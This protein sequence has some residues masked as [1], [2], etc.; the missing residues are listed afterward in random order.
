MDLILRNGLIIDGTGRQQF[1][2]DIGVS[3]GRI[4]AI[5][6]LGQVGSAQITDIDGYYVTPGII[7]AHTHGDLKLLK[8]PVNCVKL[9]QGVTC[10][11]VGNCGFSFSPGNSPDGSWQNLYTNILGKSNNAAESLLSFPEYLALVDQLP[12]GQHCAA[13]IGT[14]AVRSSVRG[15]KAGPLSQAERSRAHGAVVEA[16]QSG[17]VGLSSGL[18]YPPDAFSNE[19]DLISMVSG[20]RQ[21]QRPYVVHVRGEGVRLL[22][23]VKEALN[24]AMKAGVPLHISHFKAMGADSWGLLDEAISLIED[25]RIR[26]QDVTCDCYPYAGGAT[27]MTALLPPWVMEGG[28]KEAVERLS[29]PGTRLTIARQLQDRNQ[30]WDNVLPGI[31]WGKVIVV[32]AAGEKWQGV[33]GKS[34]KD[35]S[36][37]LDSDPAEIFMDILADSHCDVACIHMSMRMADVKKILC[38]PFSLVAS[39]SIYVP[40]N[41]LHPRVWGTFARVLHWAM[42]GKLMTIEEAV[43]K[44]TLLPATRFGLKDRGIIALGAWADLTVFSGRV[45]DRATYQQ[46]NLKP[47]GI[48]HVFVE[49]RQVLDYGEYCAPGPNGRLLKAGK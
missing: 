5:G 20:L 12:L 9:E 45:K 43:K 38:L 35:I 19:E 1:K 18:I 23:S 7:D 22:S 42:S 31:G 10:E 47:D 27:T 33:A 46:S 30:E 49:G 29:N 41:A 40:E 14:G 36:D 17:A 32:S 24:I 6:D 34:I 44:M 37:L 8:E 13:M 25:A 3:S 15:M 26:G 28:T 39:D 48:V 21:S 4:A 2:A 11:V 16:V